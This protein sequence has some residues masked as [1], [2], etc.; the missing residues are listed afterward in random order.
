MNSQNSSKPPSSD[1]LAKKTRSL[2]GTSD[3]KAGAQDGH[4]GKTLK[5]VAEPTETIHHPLP[6]QCNRCHRPLPLGEALVAER[7]QVFDVPA[8]SFDVVEHCTLEVACSCGQVHVSS[9]PA[10][11]SDVVQYGPNVKALSVHLTQGQM[12]P[13]ARTAELLHDIYGLSVS[14]GTLV[15]WVGEAR[16]ALQDT[17]N[18][19]AANLHSAALV[20]A[21]ESGLRVAGKLH[22]LHIAANDAL[23]W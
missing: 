3:K 23:T 21:D 2:R 14:P 17:A 15:A 7:R 12:L 10:D 19:I 1:G 16:A 13:F 20:N 22:W 9:F 4:K 6:S 8:R 11:V 5:R 18:Q